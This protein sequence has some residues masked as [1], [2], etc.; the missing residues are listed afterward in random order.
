VIFDAE[1][2]GLCGAGKRQERL[3]R[4]MPPVLHHERASDEA[5]RI[6]V[7]VAIYIIYSFFRIKHGIS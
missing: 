4:I 7:S 5:S 2:A 6:C 3:S 1:A